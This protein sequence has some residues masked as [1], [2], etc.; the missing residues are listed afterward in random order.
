M[1]M[2]EH[3]QEIIMALAEGTLD[4][5]AAAAAETAISPCAECTTDLELQRLALSV[6]DEAPAVYMTATESSQLHS[7]LKKELRVLSSAPAP[8]TK[9]FAWGRWLSVAAGAAAVFLVVFMVLPGLEIG[10]NDDSADM[11]IAAAAP[12]ETTASAT[13]ERERAASEPSN[14]ASFAVDGAADD[15]EAIAETTAAPAETTTTV[16][17]ATDT[18]DSSVGIADS[19]PLLGVGELTPEIR[20]G[21]VTSLMTDADGL[22]L[23]DEITKSATPDVVACFAQLA[24]EL[25]IPSA[26]EALAIG[27]LAGDDGAERITV[28]YV[29]DNV[30]DA[31]LVVVDYPGCTVHEMLPILATPEG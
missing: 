13:A 20:D 3:D 14:D 17:A 11:T 9:Q 27:L 22:R 8:I 24:D 1:K 29:P 19:L 10:S 7:S 26:H 25:G 16:G 5:A 30:E 2:H 4:D 21:V 6:L 23:R 12:T 15:L 18:T 28:A 31:L